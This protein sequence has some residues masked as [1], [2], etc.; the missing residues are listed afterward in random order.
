MM[1]GEFYPGGGYFT[2]LLSHVVGPTGH[3]FGIENQGWKGAV[4]A[5]EALLAG[6]ALA[7]VSIEALPFGTVASLGRSISS[8]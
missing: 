6:G 3:V 7:N 1:V 2:R 8:G 5:D 4:K